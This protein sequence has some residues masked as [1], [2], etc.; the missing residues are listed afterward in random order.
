MEKCSVHVFGS[1]V[2]RD[3]LE[4]AA[5]ITVGKYC[6]RQSVASAVSQRPSTEVLDALQFKDGTHPFHQR[7]VN[8][9][10]QKTSL[11]ELGTGP[12]VL[13]LIEER[14]LL[15]ITR[16]GA[17]VSYSDAA[18]LFS[19]ARGLITSFVK[20]FS[21]QHLDLFRQAIGV[22][23]ARLA[24]RAVVIHRA[25]YAKGD[26][27]SDGPNAALE[28]LY[29][30]VHAQLPAAII[31]EVER[32]LLR[33][34]PTHKWGVAPYHYVDDYYL[35]FVGQLA[36]AGLPSQAKSAFTLQKAAPHPASLE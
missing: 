11:D 24:D 16:C 25:F 9:D 2:S 19:N 29:G 5:G 18:K 12:I 32:D 7:V 14:A 30:M 8:E 15:G 35:S 21:T 6:A 26:W 1:C 27:D 34:S 36:R 17:F 23:A 4:F 31:I 33:S 22:F 20:P 28:Q 10:F 13:D 3:A